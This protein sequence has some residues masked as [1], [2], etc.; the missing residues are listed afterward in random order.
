MSRRFPLLD[1]TPLFVVAASLLAIVGIFVLRSAVREGERARWEARVREIQAPELDAATVDL[2]PGSEGIWVVAGVTAGLL[3]G[4]GAYAVARA[5]RLSR[6]RQIRELAEAMDDTGLLEGD[7][8]LRRRDAEALGEAALAFARLQRRLREGAEDLVQDRDRLRAV[9][10]AMSEG[11]LAVDSER[12]ALLANGSFRRMF[13][14]ET[15]VFED[16]D[17]KEVVRHRA[18]HETIEKIL[19]DGGA[20][21]VEIELPGQSRRALAVAVG[22]LATQESA[23]VDSTTDASPKTLAQRGA[24][25]VFRDVTELRRLERL[26]HEFVANV[27]HELKTPLASI[28]AYAETLRLWAHEDPARIDLLCSRIEEAVDR[29]NSLVLDM[30]QIARIESGEQTFDIVAANVDEEIR[31]CVARFTERAAV[32]G[33]TLAAEPLADRGI[34]V[35]ADESGLRTVLDNLVDNAVKY[36]LADGTVRI[37]ARF[38]RDLVAIDVQD[39]GIGIAPSHQARI[40]E[41][42]YRVDDA[43]SRDA[44]G[45]GLGLS[46]VKRMIQAFGGSVS[47]QSAPGRGTTFTI[48][49]RRAKEAASS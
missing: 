17:Y 38:E 5:V 25:A 1:S 10:A 15:T 43:R 41:R 6:D 33:I 19:R 49:L 13:D 12:R 8:F 30:L 24:V 21:A 47:V 36:T 16:R 26:R 46:I 18:I 42:F 37:L 20:A 22:A 44:G 9:L 39:D 23:V 29:L 11:V 2:P 4:A 14:L 32:K 27:S 3:A 35:L 40:F 31:A 28:R 48:R 45:T 34:C 7:G